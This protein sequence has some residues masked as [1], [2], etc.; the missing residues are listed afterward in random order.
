MKT[1]R[2]WYLYDILH[3]TPIYRE[4]GIYKEDQSMAVKENLVITNET[5]L[6]ARPASNFVKLAKSFKSKIMVACNG[7]EV[8]AKK[9]LGIM[10]LGA[11]KGETITITAEG[12]D[13]VQA[14]TALKTL[15][16]SGFGE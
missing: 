14:F 8:D 9:I 6:H 12:E 2:V 15:V 11:K 7:N 10:T 5:G 3:T 13:E 4:Y 1:I 16:D